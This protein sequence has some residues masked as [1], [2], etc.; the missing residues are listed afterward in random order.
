VQIYLAHS[1]SSSCT[2]SNP[3][4]ILHVIRWYK[5]HHLALNSPKHSVAEGSIDSTAKSLLLTFSK[6]KYKEARFHKKEAGYAPVAEW[7]QPVPVREKV[8]DREL[9]LSHASEA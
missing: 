2:E 4:Q 1:E 7:K 9:P 6:E 8:V 3:S 5:H